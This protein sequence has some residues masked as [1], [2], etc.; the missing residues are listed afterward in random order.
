MI[1]IE[2]AIG[3]VPSIIFADS[4]KYCTGDGNYI[5][6]E[7]NGDVATIT[8]SIGRGDCPAGCTYRKFWEFKVLG[9][10]AYFIKSFERGDPVDADL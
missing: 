3:G 7:R 1:P 6:L 8:F 5:G 4:D 9:D 10:K 2:K